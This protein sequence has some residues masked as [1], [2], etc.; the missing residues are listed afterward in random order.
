M[1]FKGKLNSLFLK[2]SR[3]LRAESSG[4]FSKYSAENL[5]TTLLEGD[6]PLSLQ[7]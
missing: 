2:I 3:I 7:R 5:P 4:D 1:N 6:G